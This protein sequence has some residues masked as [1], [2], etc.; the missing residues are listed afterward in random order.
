M[1]NKKKN[2]FVLIRTY[3]D[4]VNHDTNRSPP[5]VSVSRWNNTTGPEGVPVVNVAAPV[6][7]LV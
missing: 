1:I 4:L 2:G 7:T 3:D 6:K 5:G